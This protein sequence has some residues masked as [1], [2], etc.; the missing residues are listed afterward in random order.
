MNK[1]SCI[2]TNLSMFL[3]ILLNILMPGYAQMALD[4]ATQFSTHICKYFCY[5]NW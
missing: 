2:F 3:E 5:N 4:A 1:K